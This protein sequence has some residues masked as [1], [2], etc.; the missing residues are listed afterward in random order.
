MGPD[1]NTRPREKNGGTSFG[2]R[3]AISLTAMARSVL[4]HC[5]AL[6]R[7]RGHAVV[8]LK[9][10]ISSFQATAKPGSCPERGLYAS[11][12]WCFRQWPDGYLRHPAYLGGPGTLAGRVL[13]VLS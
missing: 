1:Q 5:R 3:N 10:I 8:Y 12:F 4:S 9:R 2:T 6:V 11:H 13:R 7:Q